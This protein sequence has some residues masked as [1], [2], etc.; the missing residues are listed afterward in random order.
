LGNSSY[1]IE[2]HKS[3][4]SVWKKGELITG[5]E[6]DGS[7]YCFVQLKERVIGPRGAV[8]EAEAILREIQVFRATIDSG[9]VSD[10]PEVGITTA[11]ASPLPA[12][13]LTT[14]SVAPDESRHAEC[15]GE[16]SAASKGK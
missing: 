1:T 2:R 12:G 16:A 14:T 9:Y 4:G 5:Q 11:E 13:E 15:G 3:W 8:R 7:F 10:L 6:R